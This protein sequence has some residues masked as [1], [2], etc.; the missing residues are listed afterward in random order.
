MPDLPLKHLRPSVVS[1]DKQDSSRFHM[2]SH[3]KN[4]NNPTK[5]HESD[6]I[7]TTNNMGEYTS[8]GKRISNFS[9]FIKRM[10]TME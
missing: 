10:I 8:Q 4:T 9:P 3:T 2:I 5:K 1:S 6:K 7:L